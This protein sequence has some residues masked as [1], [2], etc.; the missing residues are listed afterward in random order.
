MPRERQNPVDTQAFYEDFGDRVRRARGEMSQAE[1]GRRIG[2]SRGS[3]S[4][5]EAGRQHVP[6][7]FLPKLV[8]VLGIDAGELIA[9][10]A[11]PDDVRVTGLAPDERRFVANVIAA[12]RTQPDD[13]AAR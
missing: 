3:V 11:M 8:S 5:L 13:A 1:L 4:N 7:H 6:L 9:P 10:P 12:A 2:L